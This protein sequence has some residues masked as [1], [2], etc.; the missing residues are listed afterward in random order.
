MI[1]SMIP[2]VKWLRWKFNVP[3][4]YWTV[5]EN[6]ILY[7]NWLGDQLGFKNYEDWY[8]ITMK[9]YNFFIIFNFYL[10]FL[11]FF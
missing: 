2:N 5:K 4:K 3:K 8:N 10:I 9:V 11:L 1:A 6:Q 7:L